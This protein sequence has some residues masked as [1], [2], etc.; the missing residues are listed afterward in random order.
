MT[1]KAECMMS[2]FDLTSTDI[3]HILPTLNG[4]RYT[5]NDQRIS[6]FRSWRTPG[7]DKLLA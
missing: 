1:Q 2:G 7:V 5:E 4:K 6:D 3:V